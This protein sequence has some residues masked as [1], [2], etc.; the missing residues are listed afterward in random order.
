M[1]SA[2]IRRAGRAFVTISLL[3]AL[4]S[5]AYGRGRG[6]ASTPGSGFITISDIHFTPFY[7]STLATRLISA[8]YR[9]WLAI[10]QSSLVRGLGTYGNETGYPLLESTLESMR[11][12]A[13]NPGYIILTGDLLAHNYRQTFN[14]YATDRSDSAYD[15]FVYKTLAFLVSRIRN[16]F[17]NT[18]VFPALGNNDSYS[19]NYSIGPRSRFLTDFQRLWQPLVARAGTSQ[20]FA[21]DFPAGG[22]YSVPDP[23]VTHRQII[24]LNTIFFSKKYCNRCDSGSSFCATCDTSAPYPGDIEMAWLT[25]ELAACARDGRHV[26]LAYHIPPGIDVFGSVDSTGG[27]TAPVTPLWQDRYDTTFRALMAAHANIIDASF[28]G[29][30]HVDD[31]RLMADRAGRAFGFIHITPAISPVYDNNPGYQI[32]AL[33]R[34]S[35]VIGNYET[36]YVDLTAQTSGWR[37]EYDFRSTYGAARYDVAALVNLYNALQADPVIRQ[38]YIAYYPV[39]SLHGNALTIRNW[40]GFRCGIENFSVADFTACCARK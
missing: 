9:H 14:L 21:K 39:S 40:H 31:F 13:S 38:H 30:T 17:P 33:D 24:L 25:K 20:S 18:P 1:R 12:S 29:H 3:A 4:I 27:S 5:H 11:R 34:S 23:I 6:E 19:G 15:R 7:D 22:F 36:R 8:D 28:A 35:G 37:K 2:I 32:F 10:F 16:Y 26:V